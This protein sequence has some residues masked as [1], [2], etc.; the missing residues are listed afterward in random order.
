MT[1]AEEGF[2][3]QMTRKMLVDWCLLY[4]EHG[5]LPSDLMPENVFVAY[6][7]EKGWVNTPLT[8]VLSTG[9]N[10]AAAF[11]RR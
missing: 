5:V 7:I 8:K 3:D 4:L 11:L 2:V 6:A 1:K 9:F 10:T